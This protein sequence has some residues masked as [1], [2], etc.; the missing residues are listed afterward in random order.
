M[1]TR[2]CNVNVVS[3][4]LAHYLLP[5]KTISSHLPAA[6]I[7]L[8]FDIALYCRAINAV[9]MYHVRGKRP[10]LRM[11]MYQNPSS[12]ASLSAMEMMSS[13]QL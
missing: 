1:S 13:P 9:S 7:G 5:N 3:I 10:V 12:Y 11:R 2:L 4:S 6:K 8:I